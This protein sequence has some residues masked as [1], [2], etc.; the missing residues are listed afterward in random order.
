M[1]GHMS[2]AVYALTSPGGIRNL[3][4]LPAEYAPPSLGTAADVLERIRTA[5]PE[6]DAS[7]PKWL[8]ISGPGHTV[9]ITVGKGVEVHDVTFYLSGPGAAVT[10]ALDIAKALRVTA[11]DTESG[12]ILTPTS[13][14]PAPPPL[15]ADELPK[16]R[17]W[18]RNP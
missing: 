8:R 12:E 11:Y 16:R 5:A 13:Q 2:W 1:L 9:E 4:D 10:V 18:R 15:D 14:P 3:D 7:D 17:W 6:L